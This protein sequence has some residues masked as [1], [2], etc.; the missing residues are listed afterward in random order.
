[1]INFLEILEGSKYP[2]SALTVINS[3]FLRSLTRAIKPEPFKATVATIS[4]LHYYCFLTTS[5][6]ACEQKFIIPFLH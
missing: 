6:K 5:R 3:I 2:F 4:K 1:M